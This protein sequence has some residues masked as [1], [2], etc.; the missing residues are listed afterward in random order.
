MTTTTTIEPDYMTVNG[1]LIVPDAI[2]TADAITLRDSITLRLSGIASD[3]SA[4]VRNLFDLAPEVRTLAESPALRSLVEPVIGADARPVR[5]ILFDKTPDSNWKVPWH[6]DLSIAVRS[7]VDTPGYGP[8]SV[9][10]GVVHVQPPVEILE[11]M[12]TLRLHLD[13]CGPDNGQVRVIAGSHRLGKLPATEASRIGLESASDTF[14]LPI[15]GI[16]MMRPLLLHASS[17]STAPSHRR[18]VHIE[19]ASRDLPGE[20]D[21]YEAKSA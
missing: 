13:D 4:N 16:L 1:Y 10:A 7:R 19:Y 15:G 20:L 14:D 6:Q 11:R 2:P 17:P 12:V 21:W 18:I 3:M 9:K 8:W 5:A